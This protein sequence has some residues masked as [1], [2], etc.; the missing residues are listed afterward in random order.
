MVWVLVVGLP[1]LLGDAGRLVVGRSGRERLVP[2]LRPLLTQRLARLADVLKVAMV[3]KTRQLW[4]NWQMDRR[5]GPRVRE[6]RPE[7][8]GR[9]GPELDPHTSS[10]PS[11]LVRRVSSYRRELRDHSPT[12]LEKVLTLK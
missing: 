10:R 5:I 9:S 3:R 11:S 8:E 6:G 2:V 7:E 4:M 12:G 1:V